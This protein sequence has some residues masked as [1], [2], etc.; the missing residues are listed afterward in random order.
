MYVFYHLFLRVEVNLF[1]CFLK[2][3]AVGGVDL[4][5]R[6]RLVVSFTLQQL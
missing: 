3:Q 2:L 6:W 5:T 4:D 1:L